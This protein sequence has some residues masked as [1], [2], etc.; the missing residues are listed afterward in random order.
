M[1]NR[2]RK[3]VISISNPGIQPNDSDSK[4][5][6]IL[7]GPFCGP[8]LTFIPE[9]YSTTEYLTMEF[10]SDESNAEGGFQATY[11]QMEGEPCG[12]SLIRPSGKKV[13]GK[14]SSEKPRSWNVLSWKV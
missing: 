4:N 2:P 9:I 10:V 12:G 14:G 1:K 13:V 6:E 11:E 8:A 7:A 5:S 3:K